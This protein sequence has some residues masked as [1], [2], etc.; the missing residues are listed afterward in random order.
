[1]MEMFCGK[2]RFS[3]Y[4]VIEFP[5][6]TKKSY[7]PLCFKCD[8][9]FLLKI[10]NLFLLDFKVEVSITQSHEQID[11]CVLLLFKYTFSKTT[12]TITK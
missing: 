6:F 12:T 2:I 8:T 11:K 5:S 4:L 10:I 9:L 7:Y 1:M 3:F